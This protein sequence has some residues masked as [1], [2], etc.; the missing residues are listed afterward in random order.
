MLG[1]AGLW[2]AA[3]LAGVGACEATAVAVTPALPVAGGI[4]VVRSWVTRLAVAMAA[5]RV[6]GITLKV[7]ASPLLLMF[8]GETLS[9]PAGVARAFCSLTSRGS[10]PRSSPPA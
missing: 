10:V 1:W 5:G 3:E 2:A 9:T 4:T 7:A 8:G 6:V